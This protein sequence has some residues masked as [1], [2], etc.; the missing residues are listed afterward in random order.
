LD[1]VTSAAEIRE[2]T[3]TLAADPV[4]DA[5]HGIPMY[6]AWEGVQ[7]SW[8]GATTWNNTAID[9]SATGTAGKVER[10][11]A[12]VEITS[13]TCN[14]ADLNGVAIALDS[15]Q[16]LHSPATGY[17]SAKPYSTGT[18]WN[19]KAQ[20]TTA[21]NYNQTASGFSTTQPFAF[22]VPEHV[23]SDKA[24]AGYVLLYCHL[25][26]DATTK[27]T[28]KLYIGDGL[29]SG[30]MTDVASK[31]LKQ[32]SIS[33]NTYYKLTIAQIKGF[34]TME[35]ATV[36]VDVLPWTNVSVNAN[37]VANALNINVL[38]T[39]MAQCELVSGKS[40]IINWET[41]HEPL[42]HYDSGI[43]SEGRGNGSAI[44]PLWPE[45][46]Y[47]ADGTNFTDTLTVTDWF[48]VECSATNTIAW[49]D[50]QGFYRGRVK[51]T[52][53]TTA[54]WP[55]AGKYHF[56]LGDKALRM[57]EIEIELVNCPLQ[58]LVP[59]LIYYP[60]PCENLTTKVE[61]SEGS[62]QEVTGELPT[63][64]DGVYSYQWQYTLDDGITWTNV[65]ANGTGQNYTPATELAHGIKYRRKVTDGQG[66]FGYSNTVQVFVVT[67]TTM[68]NVSSSSGQGNDFW[69]TFGSN[70]GQ[71]TT[72]L[73]LRIAADSTTQVTLTFTANSAYNQT[74]TVT[75]GTMQAVNL[76]SYLSA[77][78]ASAP[79]TGVNNRSLHITSTKDIIVYAFNNT[80]ATGDATSVYPVPSWGTDYYHCGYNYTSG[81]DVFFVIASQNGTNVY[82]DALTGT[83]LATLSA[84]QIY[85]QVAGATEITGMHIVADK[86]VAFFSAATRSLIPYNSSAQDLLFEQLFSV[87]KWGTRFIVPQTVQTKTR[88]RVVA[89]HSGTVITGTDFTIPTV[90]G[91]KNSLNLDAGEWV[92]LE[93]VVPSGCYIE[94]NYPVMTCAYLV[95]VNYVSV[96]STMG[97]PAISWTPPIEQVAHNVLIAP[98]YPSNSTN[99]NQHNALIVTAT[100]GKASTTVSITGAAPVPLSG[101]TWYDNAASGL[102]FCSYAL[103]NTYFR[104]DNPNGLVIGVY[105]LGSAMSYYYLAGSSAR[106]LSASLKINGDYSDEIIGDTYGDC[107]AITFEC[108]AS[109]TPI[110]VTWKINGVTQ[111]A[112]NNLTSWS[113]TLPVDDYVLEM[114]AVIGDNTFTQVTWFKVRCCVTP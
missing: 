114:E 23:L 30:F 97:D 113:A 106:N 78:Y 95:C 45:F 111:P 21:A 76:G 18:F 44:T 67:P 79:V 57:R 64:G 60:D 69:L 3:L 12:K 50:A 75:G 89:S 93:C 92:E 58:P 8:N 51:L 66:T 71:T 80:T 82:Q 107:N 39:N 56:Y 98:F 13:V 28:Y 109:E 46:T 49:P 61:E 68:P 34:G 1:A 91:S 110:S 103:S 5:S 22:I 35:S 37:L 94:S 62:N 25:A 100:A 32:L 86:P 101:V 15:I 9:F 26:N 90:T 87:D 59:G 54:A 70:L 72:Y 29:A 88:I 53:I 99:L 65:P 42:F 84:G 77:I 47:A 48:T 11:Y 41:N 52:S 7:L 81:A 16:F 40:L 27:F 85:T 24:N 73:E 43:I 31:T 38:L 2:K 20:K 17:V 96:G 36:Y 83:L 14:Y 33:R 19:S 105:G 112:Y 108:D 102:S 104:F 74:I 10:L 63:G 4:V 55:V 6:K